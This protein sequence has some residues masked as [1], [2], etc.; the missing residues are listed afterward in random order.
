MILGDLGAKVLR[1]EEFGPLSGR[2]AQQSGRAEV[3][4]EGVSAMP[5]DIGLIYPHS[6]FNALNR[7]KRSIA[8]NLRGSLAGTIGLSPV[9]EI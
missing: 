5:E 7:N 2:R 9:I 3:S 6:P 1:V 8:L 4:P